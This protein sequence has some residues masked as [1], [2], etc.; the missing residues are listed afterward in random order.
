MHPAL[1]GVCALIAHHALKGAAEW[2]G[3]VA[4]SLIATAHLAYALSTTF[5]ALRV[6]DALINARIASECALRERFRR[7]FRARDGALTND[8]KAGGAPAAAGLRAAMR[9]RLA[10]SRAA[11]RRATTTG[12]AG[13]RTLRGTL[14]PIVALCVA[15]MLAR[16]GVGVSRAPV[17]CTH[18]DDVAAHGDAC[19]AGSYVM[20]QLDEHTRTM[21]RILKTVA[22]TRDD[23]DPL[24]R[25]VAIPTLTQ[26]FV[27]VRCSFLFVCIIYS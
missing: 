17:L 22:S 14:A 4:L 15:A 20:Q 6:A 13:E 25:D 2:S 10:V 9:Q 27:K 21:Y 26:R 23:P 11:V 16:A 8:E 18:P 19:L 5:G 7:A 3:R 24:S 12:F 1:R